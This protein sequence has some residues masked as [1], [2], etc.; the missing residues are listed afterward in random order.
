MRE[1]TYTSTYIRCRDTA[2][3]V[4]SITSVFESEGMCRLASAPKRRLHHAPALQCNRWKLEVISGEGG[5]H[6]LLPTPWNLLADR[7]FTDKSSRLVNLAK[8]LGSEAF[9]LCTHDNYPDEHGDVLLETNGS[10]AFATGR[11]RNAAPEDCDAPGAFDGDLGF[12]GTPF[13]GTK[14]SI[15]PQTELIQQLW[16]SSDLFLKNADFDE[17]DDC[18]HE[19]DIEFKQRY[20]VKHLLGISPHDVIQDEQYWVS[21]EWAK[22]RHFTLWF[23]WPANDRPEPADVAPM[24]PPDVR[25]PT[26]ELV[27]ENDVVLI[28]DSA[29]LRPGRVSGFLYG[30]R[31]DGPGWAASYVLVDENQLGNTGIWVETRP[32]VEWSAGRLI[33]R[34][35]SDTTQAIASGIEAIAQRAERGNAEAQLAWAV[36][37]LKGDGVAKDNEKMK[38]WLAQA[39]KQESTAAASRANYLL[40]G[41]AEVDKKPSIALQYFGKAADAGLREAQF[42]AALMFQKMP[43]ENGMEF[44]RF[45]ATQYYR[46]AKDQGSNAAEYN[47]HHLS[48]GTWPMRFFEEDEIK[49]DRLQ[50]LADEGDVVAQWFYGLSLEYGRNGATNDVEKALRYYKLGAAQNF[51]PAIC[52]LADKFENGVGVSVDLEQ[53]LRLYLQAAEMDVAAAS[54]SL[55]EMYRDGRG[56]PQDFERAAIWLQKAIAQGFGDK[57]KDALKNLP[58]STLNQAKEIALRIKNLAPNESPPEKNRVFDL[59]LGVHDV[60]DVDTMKLCLELYSYAGAKGHAQALFQVAFFHERGQAGLKPDLGKALP[61]YIQ[62]AEL[63]DLDSQMRLSELYET[64]EEGV[65]KDAGR[66]RHWFKLAAKHR[67]GWEAQYK[68]GMRDSPEPTERE[69]GITIRDA[70][71]RDITDDWLIDRRQFFQKK[72][73]SKLWRKVVVKFNR[74]RSDM[75]KT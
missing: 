24:P 27:A 48:L 3:L 70:A 12:Y 72:S 10:D 54:F 42:K 53:A 40:G 71:G 60:D 9:L 66:A 50:V 22:T 32:G 35:Q 51:G 6:F 38:Y 21:N 49:A 62:S 59:A 56:V 57:A 67:S 69:L 63:G 36:R 39:S 55:G 64:G 65:K 29:N 52:N 41:L 74:I 33:A 34:G 14:E 23:E 18:R 13:F 47:L 31:A 20:F 4:Q 2:K 28:S 1:Y 43:D 26:G 44:N 11:W 37:L 61:I 58:N 16:Q 46:W 17:H 68:L 75:K 25:Y 5:W 19:S 7:A 45:M 73:W 30:H 8:L 15:Q